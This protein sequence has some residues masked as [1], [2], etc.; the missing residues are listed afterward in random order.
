MASLLGRHLIRLMSSVLDIRTKER[1]LYYE[2]A[3][4]FAN[5]GIRT[6]N[7]VNAEVHSN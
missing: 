2:W 1:G 7:A 3:L 5:T 4:A 6:P